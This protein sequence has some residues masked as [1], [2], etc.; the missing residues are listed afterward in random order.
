MVHR[1]LFVRAALTALLVAL[2]MLGNAAASEPNPVSSD[3]TQSSNEPSPGDLHS[4]LSDEGHLAI[5]A[6]GKFHRF[7]IELANDNEERA[8]GLMFRTKMADDH[9]MLFD[10]GVTQQIYMWMKNTYISLDMVFVTDDGTIHHIVKSTTPLSQSIIGSGGPVRYVLEV[11]KGTIDR[12][13]A[14]PGDKLLHQVFLQTQT[15]TPKQTK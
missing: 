7:T 9:G 15:Q 14:E 6:N 12:I 8:K 10:F 11:K 2:A 1:F 13:G 4:F 5:Y 3:A